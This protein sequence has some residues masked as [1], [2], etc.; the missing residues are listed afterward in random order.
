LGQKTNTTPY[1]RE[2]KMHG[3]PLKICELLSVLAGVHY[4]ERVSVYSPQNILKAKRAIKK[5]FENQINNLGFSIIEVL[6]PCPTYLGLS[7]Q[8]AVKW[9]GEE[10]VKEYPLKIFKGAV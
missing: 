3:L 4:A 5:A 7:P 10:M 1:G 9:V 8:E 6:S 2:Q